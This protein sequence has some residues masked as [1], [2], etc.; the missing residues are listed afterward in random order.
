M[1]VMVVECH[2]VLLA[3]EFAAIVFVV[4]YDLTTL[5]PFA[6]FATFYQR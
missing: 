3:L 2:D 5:R 4:S 1:V 6:C